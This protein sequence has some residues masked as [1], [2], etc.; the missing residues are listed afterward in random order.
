M[1]LHNC[2][3][4]NKKLPKIYNNIFSNQFLN[5]MNI[6]DEKQKY[7]NGLKNRKVLVYYDEE[8]TYDLYVKLNEH[9][10]VATIHKELGSNIDTACGQLRRKNYQ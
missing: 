2:K 10:I 9:G 5:K 7:L 3:I 4:K 1:N 6:K 8:K